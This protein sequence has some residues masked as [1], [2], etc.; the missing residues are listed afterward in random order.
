MQARA[1]RCSTLL[2]AELADGARG[3]VR[4]RAEHSLLLELGGQLAWLLSPAFTLN[5]RALTVELGKL[6]AREGDR[7]ARLGATLHVGA[8]EVQLEGAERWD[9]TWRGQAPAG[10][11]LALPRPPSPLAAQLTAVVEHTGLDPRALASIVGLGPGST[12]EGDDVLLGLRAAW[13]LRQTRGETVAL[14]AIDELLRSARER[15]HPVSACMLED[16]TQDRY[17]EALAHVLDALCGRGPLE[18]ALAEL[19]GLGATSG[20]AMEW[21]VH[22]GLRERSRSTPGPS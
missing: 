19:R 17:P 20:A 18:I 10:A 8:D 21:G 7:V 4:A 3:V 2:L 9:P 16:A 15:T 14:A 22:L 6:R 13:Q 11:P 12:P 5:P 1:L